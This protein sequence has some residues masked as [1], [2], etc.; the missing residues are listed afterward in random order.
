MCAAGRGLRLLLIMVFLTSTLVF[1]AERRAGGTAFLQSLIIPGW[2]QASL[3][4]KNSALLFAGTELS[5]IGAV[6]ALKSYSASSRDDYVALAHAYANIQGG[7]GHDFYVDVGNWMNVDQYNEQRLR[8]R[9][10][11]ALYTN[12][13]DHW[14]WDSDGHR[15][16]FKKVRIRSDLAKNNVVYVAGALVANHII[17]AL[18]AGRTAAVR[19][20]RAG[21]GLSSWN[22]QAVPTAR[23]DGVAMQAHV[24]F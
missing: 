12:L 13:A 8:D 21:R 23:L 24:S 14:Q 15:G 2:G 7:H 17:S 9:E 1:G 16:Q 22:L 10:F 6:L 4:Q 20:Q 3:G 5:L 19:Q 11:D 18:H